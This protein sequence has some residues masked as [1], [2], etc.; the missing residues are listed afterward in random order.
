VIANTSDVQ[1]ASKIINAPASI[2]LFFIYLLH[3]SRGPSCDFTRRFQNIDPSALKLV[4]YN[5][6]MTLAMPP[7]QSYQVTCLRVIQLSSPSP[8]I[9]QLALPW[10]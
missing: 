1:I 4:I 8:G 2:I 7:H 6:A 3:L 10:R 9:D 5:D